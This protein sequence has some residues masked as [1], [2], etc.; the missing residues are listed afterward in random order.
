MARVTIDDCLVQI[1]SRFDLTLIAA[2]RA[3]QLARGAEPH[4]PWD[5][6]K[7]TVLALR[8]IAEGQVGTNVLEEA[9]LP[10]VPMPKADIDLR[11]F[12]F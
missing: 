7:S 12:D 3:R 6:H 9:D 10:V 8:E 5:G 11:D 2:K 4:Q 1:P